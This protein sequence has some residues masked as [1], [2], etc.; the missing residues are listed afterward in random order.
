MI[1]ICQVHYAGV[2]CATHV[3]L[4]AG[5]A[6]QPEEEALYGYIRK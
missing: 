6:Y 3:G 4:V 2:G 5:G 1:I